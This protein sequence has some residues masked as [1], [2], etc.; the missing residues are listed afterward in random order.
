LV[1]IPLEYFA[2]AACLLRTQPQADP[3]HL[4][5]IGASRGS[6]AAQLM[7]QFYPDLVENAVAYMPSR[8]TN[9][10]YYQG[11]FSCG[12]G[13]S[14]WTRNGK[15]LLLIPIPLNHVRGTVLAIAGGDDRLWDS[16]SCAESIAQERN[17]TGHKH[18]ALLYPKA[19]H[20]VAIFPYLP[21]GVESGGM[22]LGGTRAANAQ[23][24]AASWPQVLRLLGT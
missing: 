23:A 22:S 20:A 1:R 17:A 12:R 11:C 2:S 3:R 7:A 18:R 16:L 15:D 5:V 21:D 4:T 10:A 8:N 6:E 13:R 19:G 9:P 14:A 24:R